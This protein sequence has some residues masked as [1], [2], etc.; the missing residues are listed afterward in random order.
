MK[1]KDFVLAVTEQMAVNPRA[2]L[3]GHGLSAHIVKLIAGRP[4]LIAKLATVCFSTKYVKQGAKGLRKKDN[5]RIF[6]Y[7]TFAEFNAKGRGN[8]EDFMAKLSDEDANDFQNNENIV[9]LC[10]LPDT[11]QTGDTAQDIVTGKSIMLKFDNAIRKEQKTIGGFYI[12][13]MFGKSAFRPAEIKKAEVKA[14]VNATKVNRKQNTPAKIKRQLQAKAKKRLAVIKDKNKRLLER[15]AAA[16]AQLKQIADI[17][18]DFGAK[19]SNPRD[20]RAAMKA[21]NA[22]TKK[23]LRSLNPAE[24]LAY[25]EIVKLLKRNTPSSIRNAKSLLKALNNEGLTKIVMNGNLTTAEA[26]LESR[27]K[28]IRAEIR[29]LRTKANMYLERYETADNARRRAQ[30]KFDLNKTLA[31]IKLAK[32]R[33][34][35]YSGGITAVN[36]KNK[37]ALLKKINSQI[38]DNIAKGESISQALNSA[39][40]KLTVSDEAKQQLHDAVIKQVV[41]GTPTQFA[42]QQAV[43]QLPVAAIQTTSVDTFDIDEDYRVDVFGTEGV[44]DEPLLAGSL[45]VRNILRGIDL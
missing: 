29:N 34:K 41:D 21:Y 39:I 12:A 16:Q 2:V 28:V 7:R 22:D 25:K 19:S 23:F 4:D 8:V 5:F 24:K 30:A 32:S 35:A 6:G 3:A 36:V 33:L 38:A 15:S 26:R 17:G 10:A 9:V 45:D 37:T 13:I 40:Q 43:Q 31:K 14:R 18:T 27:K 42:V 1:R 44:E 11:N 20:I